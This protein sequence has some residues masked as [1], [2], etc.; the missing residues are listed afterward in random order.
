MI[1]K[2]G[3]RICVNTLHGALN[4]VPK[5][6]EL[7]K[8]YEVNASF[9]FALGE[10]RSGRLIKTHP[11]QP[12]RGRGSLLSR[13]YTS[14]RSPPVMVDHAQGIMH[15]V[16]ASGHEVGILSFDPVSWVDK[17]AFEGQAWTRRELSRAVEAFD[18]AMGGPPRFHAAAGWQVNPDLLALEEEFGFEY[19]ADVRGKTLFLPQL[20]QVDSSCVQ[21]PTTL[22]TINELL[23]LDPVA[24][25]ENVHE[26]LYAE[27]QYILPHGHVFSLD[28]ESEGIQYLAQMEK[29][30]VM[31]RGFGEGL[32]TLGAVRKAV[33]EAQ[34]PHHQIGWREE[35]GM[36]IF[37]ASQAKPI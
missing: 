6:L 21:I 15:A 35:V 32:S 22:P 34:L 24:T 13:M 33:D 27:S 8:Q 9:F 26:F 28:A 31:W 20:Q 16:E 10:D 5:L 25:V 7:F 37:V 36:N 30:I 4:G 11:Q 14:L 18:R 1:L 2:I 3:L 17:A 29:L 23:A 19:S 12:W